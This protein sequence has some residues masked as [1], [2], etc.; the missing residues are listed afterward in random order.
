LTTVSVVNYHWIA[1]SI[2]IFSTL[3]LSVK[4]LFDSASVVNCMVTAFDNLSEP[5]E[6]ESKLKII[7][8]S[9]MYPADENVLEID[10]EHL[11]A[12]TKI[13]K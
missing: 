5:V 13:S 6:V 8:T 1:A 7:K 4:Y 10:A 2:F 12:K 3:V 11:L 9:D